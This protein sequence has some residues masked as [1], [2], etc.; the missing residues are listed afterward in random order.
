[1]AFEKICTLDDIWEGD[2]ASFDTADG[3]EILLVYPDG[4]ELKAFQGICPHQNFA[5]IDGSLADN[6]LTCRAHLWQFDMRSGQGVNPSDCALANYPLKVLDDDVY[7]D[8]ADVAPLH[9][10]T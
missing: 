7:V 8:V 9:S 3:T 1:M 5:L 10:H 4:G 6:V 2:M